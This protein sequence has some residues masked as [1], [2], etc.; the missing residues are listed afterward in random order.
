MSLLLFCMC[1]FILYVCSNCLVQLGRSCYFFF[2][3]FLGQICSAKK[4]L[5][6]ALSVTPGL[7]KTQSFVRIYCEYQSQGE[8]F[9]ILLSFISACSG[10]SPPLTTILLIFL[11]FEGLLFGIFT[12]IMFGTQM[13][14][15]CTDE[16]VSLEWLYFN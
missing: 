13:S 8:H 10:M 7:S 2:F 1:A 14:A 15:V 11:I 9:R 5:V 6:F 12:G 16:T 4:Y 3:A